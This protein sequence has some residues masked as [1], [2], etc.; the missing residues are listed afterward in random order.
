MS[1]IRTLADALDAQID[2][3]NGIV[4]IDGAHDERGLNYRM[5]SKSA[6]GR[7]AVL[8]QQGM[9]RGDHLILFVEDNMR[10][11]Q[12]FWGAIYG[13]IVPVPIA[14]GATP[15]QLEKLVRVWRHLDEPRIVAAPKHIERVRDFL[16]QRGEAD[17][18]ARLADTAFSDEPPAADQP[19][20]RPVLDAQDTAF[21]QFSSGSTG[22]PK[23]V[24]L[25]HANVLANIQ[26][27]SS[28]SRFGADEI[29]L[30]WMP[31]THDMGLIG[32]HLTLV[33]NGFAHHL[34]T[35]DLFARRP[36][37]WLEKAAETRATLLCS[38][39]FGYRHTLRAI[40]AKG[41]P[42]LD[43]S[44]VRLIYN[45]AE[46]IAPALVREFLDTLAPTGLAGETMFAVYGLA[47][48]SLAATF[49]APG[50]GLRTV[51]VARGEL[52]VGDTVRYDDSTHALELVCLGTPV[53]AT[54]VRL[55]DDN[56]QAVG[57]G[58][59]GRVWI[60]G[61]NV[62]AGYH[63]NPQ[64]NAGALM[65]DGWL[66][67]GDL[68][69]YHDGELVITG[70]AKEIIFVNGQNHY[71]QDIEALLQDLPGAELNKLAAAGVQAPSTTEQALVL[72]VVFRGHLEDFAEIA[73]TLRGALNQRAGLVATRVLPISRMP[74]T[75]SGKLQRA[76]LA[77]QYAEGEFDEIAAR[78][79]TLLAT[80][81]AEQP[82]PASTDI[83]AE[84]KRICD[85]VVPGRD[86]G[87]DDDLF[88]IGLSSLELA[89]IHEG[90]ENR[91]PDRLEMTD[92]FEY[93]TINALAAYLQDEVAPA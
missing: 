35:P 58:V 52:G 7:L 27:I 71:P 40:A 25:S 44:R 78:L 26:A 66:D 91:W 74:K 49:P 20:E 38:P 76:L 15:A 48:A 19:A 82:V 86:I 3:P 84:L 43:L 21:I 29:A 87:V 83:A 1:G 69:F 45:G 73:R 63:D 61:A 81:E 62:T 18:A 75:T 34:M 77:R 70:R 36:L 39:N 89:Q 37:L 28:G 33:Y 59:V 10:F 32:F 41:R 65:G 90:I 64:A 30:S 53:A 55:A 24:V 88:E 31:L 8:Q 46:P 92:L 5:L 79:D 54:E 56:G 17:A 11:L 60:R 85:E 22:D 2:S 68:G 12:F 93:P 72:F 14:A 13:A 80:E 6:E 47:E 23:G 16:E 67:T 4:F 9:R 51:S 42:E 57:D 50:R